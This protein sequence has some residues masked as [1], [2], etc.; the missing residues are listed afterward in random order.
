[1][2][3]FLLSLPLLIL[4]SAATFIYPLYASYKAITSPSRPGSAVSSYSWRTKHDPIAAGSASGSGSGENGA[5]NVT[6]MA[7]LETWL[8]YWSVIACIQTVETFLEW[9]WS[10]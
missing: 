7:E 8:M 4:N 6:E 5:S 3:F 10:W 1:M 9:S 2:A